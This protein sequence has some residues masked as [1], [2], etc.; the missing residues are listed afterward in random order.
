MQCPSDGDVCSRRGAGLVLLF[1]PVHYRRHGDRHSVQKHSGSAG[2]TDRA[3]RHRTAH[4]P[5][6][7]QGQ[8]ASQSGSQAGRQ[9]GRPAG[10]QAG[11]QAGSQ[12]VSRAA[13]ADSRTGLLTD[14]YL[15]E[16]S[17]V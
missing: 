14:M 2:V 12:S 13:P 16:C 5:L 7:A 17:E 6:P 1:G 3:L 4:Q 8:S 15:P 10:R 11:R 9:A